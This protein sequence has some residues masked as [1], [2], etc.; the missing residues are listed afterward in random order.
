M[1]DPSRMSRA[2]RVVRKRERRKEWR[3]WRQG[4]EAPCRYCRE[5]LAAAAR[6]CQ[7]CGSYQGRFAGNLQNFQLVGA[8]A[9]AL[10]FIVLNSYEPLSRL[11]RR[12]VNVDMVWI[13]PLDV[14]HLEVAFK[15]NGRS[16]VLISDRGTLI[17]S[18][19]NEGRNELQ[20]LN[21]RLLPWEHP[22]L[23]V[24]EI[25]GFDLS[26]DEG[27][28]WKLMIDDEDLLREQYC[29]VLFFA[30]DVKPIKI[31]SAHGGRFGTEPYVPQL[32]GERVVCPYVGPE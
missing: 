25:A 26:I 20:T 16:D 28:L 14:S 6:R 31:P 21:V 30:R 8:I 17:V 32:T 4:K 29:A 18:S 15:N 19:D 22:V 1:C 27:E 13:N 10:A 7:H 12:Q 5:P 9:F 11:F 2:E 3:A 23:S 24:D